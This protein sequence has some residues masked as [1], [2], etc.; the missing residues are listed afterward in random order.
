[1]SQG[2]GE[3]RT[4]GKRE[5]RRNRERGGGEGGMRGRAAVA[6]AGAAVK[7]GE[8]GSRKVTKEIPVISHS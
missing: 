8:P 1:M 5:E 7:G 3:E 4:E 2:R 6:T